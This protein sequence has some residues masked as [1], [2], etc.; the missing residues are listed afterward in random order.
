MK[1]IDDIRAKYP[2]LGLAL[3]GLEPGKPVT[4]E[5]LT[6]DGKVFPF[7]AATEAEAVAL[8]FPDEDTVPT[9]AVSVFD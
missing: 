3:Y 8:A 9:P 5:L 4:L 1:T 7:K 6:P 2:H